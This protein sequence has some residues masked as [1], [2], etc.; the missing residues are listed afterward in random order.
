MHWKI[1]VNNASNFTGRYLGTYRTYLGTYRTYLGTYEVLSWSQGSFK[2]E[3]A[4]GPLN[5][6]Q[7]G[8]RSRLP[9]VDRALQKMHPKVQYLPTQPYPYSYHN[10][11]E[12]THRKILG[13]K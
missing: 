2:D 7:I 8:V 4:G 12:S 1:V 10:L 9:A 11:R 13:S 6:L 5:I 3:L